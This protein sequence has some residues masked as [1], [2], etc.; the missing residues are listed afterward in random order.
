MNGVVNFFQSIFHFIF[1]RLLL[2]RHLK[3]IRDNV[4]NGMMD[5]VLEILLNAMSLL[6]FIDKDFRRN[7]EG[8]HSRYSFSSKKGEIQAAFETKNNKM[9]VYPQVIANSNITI[10]FQ[11]G[12]TLWRMLTS[13]NVDIFSYILKNEISYE[14]NPNYVF[15]FGYMA[16][17][18]MTMLHL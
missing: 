17:H 18:I 4:T 14:G 7:I 10:Y 2:N 8:F 6:L 9:K 16:N 3:R 1:G 13:G 15:K 11:D 5:G 12:E